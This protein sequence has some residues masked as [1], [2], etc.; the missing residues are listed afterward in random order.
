MN[1]SVPHNSIWLQILGSWFDSKSIPG[2]KSILTSKSILNSKWFP[3]FKSVPNSVYRGFNFR[4]YFCRFCW[5]SGKLWHESRVK[6]RARPLWDFRGRCQYQILG[7]RKFRYPLYTGWYF[8]Y[9]ISAECGYQKLV[10]KTYNG[11]RT[12]HILTNFNPNL[13]ALNIEHFTY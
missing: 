9:I 5:Q 2:S 10:T 1:P 8:T 13:S 3:I 4:I 12:S 6:Y 7:V 11:G